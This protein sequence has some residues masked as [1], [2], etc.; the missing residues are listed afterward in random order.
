MSCHL[1]L[2][3]I[4]FL[5]MIAEVSIDETTMVELKGPHISKALDLMECGMMQ[6]VSERGPMYGKITKAGYFVLREKEIL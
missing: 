6:V 5:K 4:K 2:H 1:N 3:E